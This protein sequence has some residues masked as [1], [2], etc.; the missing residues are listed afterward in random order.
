MGSRPTVIMMRPNMPDMRPLIT[1]CCPKLHMSV[2]PKSTK[3]KSSGAPNFKA[4]F[5][6]MGDA[7]ARQTRPKIPPKK[8][9]HTATPRASPAR[10]FFA[11]SWPSIAVAEADGV[12]GIFNRIA[13]N[14][15]P[16]I[17]DAY[18]PSSKH[19]EVT[20]D[21]LNVIGNNRTIPKEMVSPGVEPM[22]KPNTTPRNVAKIFE[23]CS[24]SD[25]EA[26]MGPFI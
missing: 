24:T 4:N 9:E 8:E 19:I 18:K 17:P 6:I 13:D 7:K 23:N 14:E 16:V 10:P 26:K 21:R 2:S 15:P 1:D 25:R 22:N 11:I 20:A 3:A 5:A 12:P